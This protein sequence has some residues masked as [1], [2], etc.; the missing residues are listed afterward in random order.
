MLDLIELRRAEGSPI[1]FN[2]TSYIRLFFSHQA[3][4]KIQR[5]FLDRRY[6]IQMTMS[7]A[8]MVHQT[9]AD[10]ARVAKIHKKNFHT[11]YP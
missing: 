5:L 8:Y 3:T 2:Q 9:A 1:N 6:T 10:A 4:E 7:I 11:I